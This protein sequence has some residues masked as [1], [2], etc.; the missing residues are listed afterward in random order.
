MALALFGVVPA[1]VEGDFA[2]LGA[3][4]FI[5]YA[6]LFYAQHSRKPHLFKWFLWPY[7]SPTASP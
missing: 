3:L 6:F 2:W 5:S 4:N 7:V 1:L